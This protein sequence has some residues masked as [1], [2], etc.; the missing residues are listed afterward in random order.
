M[1]YNAVLKY[2]ETLDSVYAFSVKTVFS[3]KTVYEH[4]AP[5]PCCLHLLFPFTEK[6]DI[7]LCILLNTFLAALKLLPFSLPYE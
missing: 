5:I 1:L 7:L 2:V 6:E 3:Q 4:V